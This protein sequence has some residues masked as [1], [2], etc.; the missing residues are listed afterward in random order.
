MGDSS[1]TVFGNAAQIKHGK[2][3]MTGHAQDNQILK[4]RNFGRKLYGNC[5]APKVKD[6]LNLSVNGSQSHQT[7]RGFTFTIHNKIEYIVIKIPLGKFSHS[8]VTEDHEGEYQF[9]N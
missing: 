4:R 5:S 9:F 6:Y 1:L 3:H 8:N 2:V 7:F